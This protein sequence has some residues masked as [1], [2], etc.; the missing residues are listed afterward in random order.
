[1][2]TLRVEIVEVFWKQKGPFPA[3]KASLDAIQIGNVGE[4]IAARL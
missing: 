2:K 1:L 3:K 4:Q